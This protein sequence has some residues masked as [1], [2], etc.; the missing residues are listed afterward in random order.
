MYENT[1]NQWMS[2]N[3]LR[4][5]M[6]YELSLNNDGIL[7]YIS[8]NK[9]KERT[10][11]KEINIKLNNN[12]NNELRELNKDVQIMNDIKNNK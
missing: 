10:K 1:I 8:L 3:Y 2:L 7:M 12:K 6:K 5:I 11:P 4:K 9:K